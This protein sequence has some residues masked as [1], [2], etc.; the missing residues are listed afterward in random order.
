MD[1]LGLQQQ[2]VFRNSGSPASALWKC[3]RLLLAWSGKKPSKLWRRLA[4]IAVPSLVLWSIFT[5]ASIF[6]ADIASKGYE[7]I[8]VLAKE[9]LCRFPDYESDLADSTLPWSRI[10]VADSLTSLQHVKKWYGPLQSSVNASTQYPRARLA[11]KTDS[12]VPCPWTGL[13][14]TKSSVAFSLQTVLLD[15]HKDLGINADRNERFGCQK[16]VTC[17]PLQTQ[18]YR[19]YV[20]ASSGIWVNFHMGQYLD[21]NIRYE[22]FTE[23]YLG[24]TGYII[25][26]VLQNDE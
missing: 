17:S 20:N 4:V 26:W 22:Y 16:N 12:T 1:I 10:R 3:T 7:Q 9:G 24:E 23:T 13:C 8:L 19:Q 21:S 11:Y 18:S 14:D 5:V 15:S 2:L 6:V 25:M